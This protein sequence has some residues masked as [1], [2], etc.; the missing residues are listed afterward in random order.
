L[1]TSEPS[2]SICSLNCNPDDAGATRLGPPPLAPG[3]SWPPHARGDADLHAGK[4]HSSPTALASNGGNWRSR[5]SVS[6]L[7]EAGAALTKA[8]RLLTLTRF[9]SFVASTIFGRLGPAAITQP[10]LRPAAGA[11]SFRS[12]P[13]LARSQFRWKGRAWL[14]RKVQYSWSVDPMSPDTRRLL[15]LG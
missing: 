13:L 8:T 6:T 9:Q 2:L 12:K 15:P 1:N 14:W 7:A 4:R 10:Q 5:S 11:S 3:A